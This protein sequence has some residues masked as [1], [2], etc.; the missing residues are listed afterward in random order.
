LVVRFKLDVTVAVFY[1]V[2]LTVFH[3]CSFTKQTKLRFEVKS[4]LYQ[5]YKTFVALEPH[6]SQRLLRCIHCVW[7][8][9]S[10]KFHKTQDITDKIQFRLYNILFTTQIW[11]VAAYIVWLPS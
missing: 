10:T 1:N 6:C 9:T 7:H 4:A 2:L 5:C 8:R 11:S 3:L